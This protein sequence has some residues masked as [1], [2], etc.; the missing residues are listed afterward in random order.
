PPCRDCG[1]ILKSA[2]IS[3]GQALVPEVIERAMRSAGEPGFFLSI[4]H[5]LQVYP[6]AGAVEVAKAAGAK[7]V[8]LNAEATP[9]DEMADAV[10]RAPIGLVLAAI[11][12]D[13]LQITHH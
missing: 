9:F 4:G 11:L 3:F 2:T 8:I 10:F 7:I 6:V 12:S 5:S 1:G 13:S